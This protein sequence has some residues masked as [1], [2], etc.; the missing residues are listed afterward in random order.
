MGEIQRIHERDDSHKE[1]EASI[2]TCF[3]FHFLYIFP[4]G[5]SANF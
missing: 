4:L 3:K 1:W 2:Y 5:P